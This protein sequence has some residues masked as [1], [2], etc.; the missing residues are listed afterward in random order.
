MNLKACL[1]PVYVRERRCLAQTKLYGCE[2]LLSIT[3]T[4]TES[5]AEE[6]Q[7]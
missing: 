3:R 5:F 6:V 1:C 2:G 4:D 7:F